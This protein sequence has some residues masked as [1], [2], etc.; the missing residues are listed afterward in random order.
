MFSLEESGDEITLTFPMR[1]GMVKRVKASDWRRV[2][3]HMDML[4]PIAEYIM[5]RNPTSYLIYAD[6]TKQLGRALA[7]MELASLRKSDVDWQTLVLGIRTF[8]YSNAHLKA[9]SRTRAT[10]TM[11]IVESLLL[12]LADEG[13]IPRNVVYPTCRTVR[14]K[15]TIGIARYST[16]SLRHR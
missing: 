16:L 2:P 14:C 5:R 8:V 13:L 1:K 6:A 4:R 12:H 7:S 10:M 15:T 11:R 3:F 9:I